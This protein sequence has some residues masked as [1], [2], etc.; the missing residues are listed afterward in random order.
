MKECS[1]I[2]GLLDAF[3]DNEMSSTEA[4]AVQRHVESC[5]SCSA[6][7]ESLLKLKATLSELP[8]PKASGSL[9]EQLVQRLRGE[10]RPLPVALGG[11]W[12][13][14]VAGVAAAMLV[15][16]VSWWAGSYRADQRMYA[17]MLANHQRPISPEAA[18]DMMTSDR[19]SL[20][21]WLNQRT[22]FIMPSSLLA[23]SE[24]ALAGGRVLS[25]DGEKV[26]SIQYHMGEKR[27]SLFAME[28][29]GPMPTSARKST[30]KGQPLFIDTYQGY[31]VVMWRE[32]DLLICAV[33]A[34]AHSGLMK[35]L[36]DGQPKEPLK[37]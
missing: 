18:T 29:H 9:R 37:V 12:G 28:S 36:F 24:M 32:G 16:A 34:L 7:V 15:V 10:K 27:V 23:R 6:H 4:A 31:N 17:S 11:R 14:V 25:M 5:S 20:W 26:A 8:R 22:S 30:F 33:S 1:D 21:R 19:Q 3:V 35:M 2:R 13:L